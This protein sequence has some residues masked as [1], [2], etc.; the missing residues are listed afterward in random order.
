MANISLSPTS[1][2]TY[3]TE[4]VAANRQSMKAS[5]TLAGR[6]NAVE[7]KVTPEAMTSTVSET[8]SGDTVISIINQTANTVKI[9]AANITLEGYT[10]I[11]EYF[12]VLADGTV[13]T[14]GGKVGGWT[15]DSL[16]LYA[17]TAGMTIEGVTN[18]SVRFW[19][20]ASYANRA[21]AKFRVTR[22]GSLYSTLG[23]IAG[24]LIGT[25]TLT[26]KDGTMKLD[27]D[28][29]RIYLNTNA[30]MEAGGTSSMIQTSGSFNIT[31]AITVGTNVTL[32]ADTAGNVFIKFGGTTYYLYKDAS[33]FL[34]VATV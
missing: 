1:E 14:I 33:N 7:L 25:T 13:E 26:S 11:N 17:A 28:N 10:T 29:N 34:K 31:G 6:V 12:K 15:I 32:N 8:I 2:Q 20:G 3:D 24:W 5:Q 30:Y 4:Q 9:S 23:Y 19:S 22:D 27:N 21:T 18:G 16:S